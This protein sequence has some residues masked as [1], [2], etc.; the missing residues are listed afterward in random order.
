MI[1]GGAPNAF[2]QEREPAAAVD[3]EAAKVPSGGVKDSAV[4]QPQQQ[5][6][7]TE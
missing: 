4:L 7:A 3:P 2:L 5:C 6:R 1:E